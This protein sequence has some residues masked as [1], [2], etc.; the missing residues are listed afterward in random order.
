M[1][2]L[3]KTG[4]SIQRTKSEANTW[5]TNSAAQVPINFGKSTEKRKTKI[6]LAVKAHQSTKCAV[7]WPNRAI[8][9][10]SLIRKTHRAAARKKENK[11]KMQIA[12]ITLFLKQMRKEEIRTLAHS[13]R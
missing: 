3:V 4:K 2:A 10:D 6:S 11:R 5:S 7:K 9:Q 13:F 12:G 1:E 8:T